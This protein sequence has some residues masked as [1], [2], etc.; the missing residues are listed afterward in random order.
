MKLDVTLPSLYSAEGYSFI[1]NYLQEQQSKGANK[2]DLE[3]LRFLTYC[4]TNLMHS[5]AQL[6]QDMY[7]L[8]K[9]N[10]KRNGFFVEFGAASGV[11]GSNT[12]LL[13]KEMAWN[14]ILAE[15][16]PI[17]HDKLATSRNTVIDH[18]CVWSKSGEK[19][20][21]LGL[22]YAPELS[23]LLSFRDSDGHVV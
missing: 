4:M 19:L 9:L 12:Y 15:P 2:Y 1:W 23:T 6:F 21:F 5:K 10:S 13:E 14:G 8:Y 22:D 17:Y 11:N 18:R 3:R 7:V 20:E 16:F